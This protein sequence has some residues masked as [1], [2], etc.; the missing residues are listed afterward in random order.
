MKK[1]LLVIL[2]TFIS[3]TAMAEWTYVAESDATNVYIDIA[4]KRKVGKKVTVWRLMD[5]KSP[6]KW[7]NKDYL[8]VVFKTEFDCGNETLKDINITAY[9]GNMQKGESLGSLN[10]SSI[11]EEIRSIVPN[12]LD[13]FVY[14]TACGKK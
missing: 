5:F 8:S 14:K 3:T 12:S 7:N 13:S 10:S 9:S 2:L 1:L 4:S 11:D 6:E